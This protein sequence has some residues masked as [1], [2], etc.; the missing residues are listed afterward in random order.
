MPKNHRSDA[1]TRHKPTQKHVRVALARW[2]ELE[3]QS[4]SRRV[5]QL[6]AEGLRRPDAES[7]ALAELESI[8][9]PPLTDEDF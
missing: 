4:W 1:E 8:G 7:F 5:S 6:L 9:A 2:G 3:R